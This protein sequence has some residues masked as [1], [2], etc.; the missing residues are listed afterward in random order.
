M[1]PFC[2]KEFDRTS[3][4]LWKNIGLEVREGFESRTFLLLSHQ[5]HVN[6]LSSKPGDAS[7]KDDID[8]GECENSPDF[9]GNFFEE[10][11]VELIEHRGD[12]K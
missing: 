2:A 9:R 5:P 12:E 4:Y 7:E 8:Q 10:F 6:L 3:F 1:N 11:F